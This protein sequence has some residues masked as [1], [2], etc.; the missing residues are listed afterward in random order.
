MA[1]RRSGP[2]LTAVAA[3]ILLAG[4]GSSGHAAHATAQSPPPPTTRPPRPEPP[5]AG[6]GGQVIPAPP[7]TGV[8]A[9]PTA[10][11]VIR[12]WSSALGHGDISGA[13]RYF[14]LPSQFINGPDTTGHVPILEIGSLGEAEAANQLL[15]CGARFISADERGRY[16]NALFRLTDRPGPGGGCGSGVGQ[17]ARTNFVIAGGRIVEWIRAPDDPGDAHRGGSP[18]E[19]PG[20]ASSH[21]SGPT[22]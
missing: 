14:A 7:P 5:N 6:S 4:C 18:P 13:A 12:A 15:P 21:G 17:L 10:V 9:D 20:P 22:V 19:R 1:V 16:V 8:P 11:N 2:L 3:G